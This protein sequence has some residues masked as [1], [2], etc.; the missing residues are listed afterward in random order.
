MAACVRR[1]QTKLSG[2]VSSLA[3]FS[4]FSIQYSNPFSDSASGGTKTMMDLFA[5]NGLT[6]LHINKLASVRYKILSVFSP[7]ILSIKDVALGHPKIRQS[8]RISSDVR[9]IPL[10]IL[11]SMVALRSTAI[12]DPAVVFAMLSQCVRA[13]AMFR[14]ACSLSGTTLKIWRGCGDVLDFINVAESKLGAMVAKLAIGNKRR[15]SCSG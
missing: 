6:N 10:A 15:S 14:S 8:A 3:N 12:A 1:S 11:K 13:F 7:T 4:I 2:R 5:R 9:P